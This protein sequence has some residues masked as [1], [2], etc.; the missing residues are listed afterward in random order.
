MRLEEVEKELKAKDKEI[1][2]L[3][4]ILPNV[5]VKWFTMEFT[6]IDPEVHAHR[7]KRIASFPS[8]VGMSQP[9]S[10]WAGIMT[11]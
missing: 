7:K 11:S 4:V 9:N 5:V 10:P 2:K 6:Y 3:K 1:T 8:P